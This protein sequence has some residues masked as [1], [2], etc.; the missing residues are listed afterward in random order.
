MQARNVLGLVTAIQSRRKF[1]RFCISSFSTESAESRRE[2]V[3]SFRRSF[4]L[5]DATH[6]FPLNAIHAIQDRYR[7]SYEEASLVLD[8]VCELASTRD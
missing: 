8:R 4:Q 6:A 3:T 7:L 1:P 5:I 2:R